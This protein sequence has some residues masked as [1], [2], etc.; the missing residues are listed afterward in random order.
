MW[1]YLVPSSDIA[2]KQGKQDL[3][4][5]MHF[6]KKLPDCPKSSQIF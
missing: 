2:L 1:D 4:I 6:D 5:Y 3:I